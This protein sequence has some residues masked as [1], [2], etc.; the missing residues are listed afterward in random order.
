MQYILLIG[1]IFQKPILKKSKYNPKGAYWEYKV[2]CE[3]DLI[4]KEGETPVHAIY[5]VINF[6]K[7]KK[8][9]YK[10]GQTV[11][12]T[13]RFDPRMYN[14]ENNQTRVKLFVF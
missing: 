12:V 6:N 5:T 13:G 9:N 7:F 14:D 10:K 4:Y 1:K 11:T 8:L 2:E 3:N